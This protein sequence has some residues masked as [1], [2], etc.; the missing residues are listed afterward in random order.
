MVYVHWRNGK[1][2]KYPVSSGNKFLDKGLETRPGLFAIFVM[3]EHHES[4][5][6]IMPICIT[7]CRSIRVSAFT[8]STE[9][10]ITSI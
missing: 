2:D 9:Q 5:S 1:I 7:L 4:S 8:Q 3:E 6:S 10:A